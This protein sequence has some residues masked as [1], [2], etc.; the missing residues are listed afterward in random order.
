MG[1]EAVGVARGTNGGEEKERGE[2][3]GASCQHVKLEQCE[4]IPPNDMGHRTGMRDRQRQRV[5]GWHGVR[6]AGGRTGRGGGGGG[7]GVG[8]GANAMHV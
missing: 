6:R 1:I 5:G 8:V 2:P 4:L 7:C 3:S